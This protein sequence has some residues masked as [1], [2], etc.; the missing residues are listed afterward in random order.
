[1]NVMT[2]VALREAIESAAGE[3]RRPLL[4]PLPRPDLV[5]GLGDW[6]AAA[7]DEAVSFGLLPHADEPRALFVD[8]LRSLSSN[9]FDEGF[10]LRFA[11]VDEAG[12]LPVDVGFVGGL[13]DPCE[14]GVPFERHG[15]RGLT[16]LSLDRLDAAGTP[17]PVGTLWASLRVMAS[18]ATQEPSA[19]VALAWSPLISTV[20]AARSTL[21]ELVTGD[22]IAGL[23]PAPHA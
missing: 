17:S 6:A 5:S 18:R 9:S 14:G 16:W 8:L 22:L 2:D 11:F 10:S 21:E 15:V 1:M 23:P 12:I 7:A 19:V 20:V 13:V 4:I 3:S